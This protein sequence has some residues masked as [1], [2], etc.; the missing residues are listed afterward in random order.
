MRKKR[1]KLRQVSFTTHK[2]LTF[3]RFATKAEN[4]MCWCLLQS[5]RRI[6][7]SIDPAAISSYIL[8]G[9]KRFKESIYTPHGISKGTPKTLLK[10]R[11]FG[12]AALEWLKF[13]GKYERMASLLLN[14]VQRNLIGLVFVIAVRLL[15]KNCSDVIFAS[16]GMRRKY[17][18]E[19]NNLNWF[20]WISF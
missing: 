1:W 3:I 9:G 2:Y 18:L 7:S 6:W 13:R 14:V 11:L 12:Y 8:L 17:L 15:A 10:I 5:R 4:C 16:S 19:W 20:S